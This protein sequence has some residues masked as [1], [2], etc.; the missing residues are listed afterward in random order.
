MEIT[1]LMVAFLYEACTE[2]SYIV[3]LVMIK[4]VPYAN[5]GTGLHQDAG[6]I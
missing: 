4:S 2:N 1:A 5:G 6:I 3:D